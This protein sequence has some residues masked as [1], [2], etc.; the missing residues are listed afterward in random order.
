MLSVSWFFFCWSG[1]LTK[2]LCLGTLSDALS[3]RQ[4]P[5]G[6]NTANL[7]PLEV[8]QLLFRKERTEFFPSTVV[9]LK[10]WRLHLAFSLNNAV[11][12][13]IVSVEIFPGA[14]LLGGVPGLGS[15]HW[16]S[17]PCP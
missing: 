12:E 17:K 10:H 3:C 5:A 14:A 8:H 2:Q 6:K 4:C 16:F 1:F 7:L 11:N 15:E 9:M 13:L